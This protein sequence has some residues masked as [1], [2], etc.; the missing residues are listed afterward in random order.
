[1]EN[2]QRVANSTF[3]RIQARNG[4]AAKNQSQMTKLL[5]ILS[6]AGKREE[7]PELVQV[8]LENRGKALKSRLQE[9]LSIQGRLANL[10][11]QPVNIRRS[12]VRQSLLILE[13]FKSLS[14]VNKPIKAVINELRSILEGMTSGAEMQDSDYSVVWI[15]YALDKIRSAIYANEKALRELHMSEEELESQPEEE[16]YKG[17]EEVLASAREEANA[18]DLASIKTR[19]WTVVR[20]PIVPMSKSGIFDATKFQK[21]GIKCDN[22]AGYPMFRNQLVIGINKAMLNVTDK[23]RSSGAAI[24]RERVLSAATKVK[25]ILEKKTGQRLQ[26]VD[27]RPHGAQGGAWFWLM[28]EREL[29]AFA[30]CC[31]GQRIQLLNWGFSI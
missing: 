27:Q 25:R 1:V 4:L 23:E 24:P 30:A 6:M 5:P 31:P 10:S 12:R 3:D 28:P 2:N 14:G 19:E 22:M 7:D 8:R 29:N 18:A 13:G 11:D 9:V 26:F 15:D 21:N 17:F 16:L 20:A